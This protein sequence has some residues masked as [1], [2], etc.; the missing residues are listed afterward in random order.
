[1]HNYIPKLKACSLKI[2]ISYLVDMLKTVEGIL[3]ILHKVSKEPGLVGFE[4]GSWL[5]E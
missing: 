4:T 3:D 2:K 5:Q 1:M